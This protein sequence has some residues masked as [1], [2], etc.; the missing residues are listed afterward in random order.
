ML[1][2]MW[3][4]KGEMDHFQRS[5][6]QRH[7]CMYHSNL[8]TKN[9]TNVNLVHQMINLGQGKMDPTFTECSAEKKSKMG[10]Q[11]N[12]YIIPHKKQKN[13]GKNGWQL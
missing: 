1:L 13:R 3:V 6:L 7:T 4:D 10:I 11:V 2:S 5:H 9:Y 12:Y 8:T